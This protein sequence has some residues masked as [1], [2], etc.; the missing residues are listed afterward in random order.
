MKETANFLAV[1]LGASNGRVLLAR[2]DGSQFEL[3]ELHRFPNGPVRV[4]GHIHWDFLRIW[5]EILA[6]F[7]RY[8][9]LS[10]RPLSGIGVDTWGVDFALLDRSGRLLG[11]PF[12]YRDA[13]TDGIPE[14][15]FQA[16]TSSVW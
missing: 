12:H 7:A 15:V 6:G 9:A 16:M 11:N 4:L 10:D 3:E 5:S 8:A 2:W 1:D 14:R 13:R